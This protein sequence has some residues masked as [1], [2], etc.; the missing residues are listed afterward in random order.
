MKDG[1]RRESRMRCSPGIRLALFMAVFALAV[2]LRDRAYAMHIAEGILPGAWAGLWYGVAAVFVAAGLYVMSRELR[3]DRSRGPQM[4][5]MGALIFI[6]SLLPIPVPISGTCSHPCGTPMASVIIGPAV[7]AL[8]GGI[9]L[10]F[11][12]LFFAHGGIT[13]WGANVVSMAVVGSF[14]G[15]FVYRLSRRLGA[16]TFLAAFFAGFVGDL[17]VYLVTA[18]QLALGVPTA[19][20]VLSRWGTVFVAFL[21]TQLPLAVLEGVVTGG[22]VAAIAGRRPEL[23]A[24]AVPVFARRGRGN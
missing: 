10:L 14:A 16:N 2:Q 24:E 20:G 5:L 8:M 12:A 23:L 7:S 9:A 22:V 1:G 11:Q 17:C 4:A 15:F 18:L 21:P 13:T 3:R 6:F 19:A